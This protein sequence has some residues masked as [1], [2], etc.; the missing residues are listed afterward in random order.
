[1]YP[2]AAVDSVPSILYETTQPF[3]VPEPEEADVQALDLP[4]LEVTP[5]VAEV[6]K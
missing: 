6:L 1:M 5:T 3:G 4:L 2:V